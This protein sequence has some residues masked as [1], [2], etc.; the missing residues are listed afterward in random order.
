MEK[1]CLVYDKEVSSRRVFKYDDN[2]D[3]KEIIRTLDK[4]GFSFIS[5]IPK[6]ELD[7]YISKDEIDN[8]KEMSCI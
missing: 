5:I 4:V 2:T 6:N 7:E 3:V 8:L 1:Y